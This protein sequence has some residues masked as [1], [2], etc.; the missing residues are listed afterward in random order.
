[1]RYRNKVVKENNFAHRTFSFLAVFAIVAFLLTIKP[2]AEVVSKGVTSLGV[3]FPPMEIFVN[4]AENL[5]NLAIGLL[6]LLL[7]ALIVVPIIKII[8]T[9]VA[10]VTIAYSV[11]NL[12]QTFTGK[13]TKNI[14][15]DTPIRRL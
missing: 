15:P 14:L 5:R 4:T 3:K 11:Y 1:M 13:A 9:V 10:I 2:I 12:Y 6:L 7:A 8:V